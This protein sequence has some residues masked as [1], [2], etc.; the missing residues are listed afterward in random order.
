MTPARPL[1]GP[2]RDDGGRT[3]SLV[4]GGL[5]LLIGIA[6]LVRELIPQIS[7]DLFWPFLLVI[8]GVVVL[9]SAFRGDGRGGPGTPR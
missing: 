6:F 9:A 1:G 3:A 2:G 4:I 7:F 8:L 5:L